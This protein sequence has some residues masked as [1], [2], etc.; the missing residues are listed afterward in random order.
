MKYL[1]LSALLIISTTVSAHAQQAK[2]V[3]GKWKIVKVVTPEITLD[4]ENI[5]A[6]RKALAKQI[7]AE[8]GETP[9]SAVLNMA[10]ESVIKGLNNSFFDFGTDGTLKIYSPVEGKEETETYTVDYT[11]N[12]LTAVSKEKNET[13]VMKIAF[14]GDRLVMNI[15]EKEGKSTIVVKRVKG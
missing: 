2:S 13:T 14:V 15:T 8:S 12:T 11:T 10:V 4:T 3:V 7:A 9:D 1:L 5:P 6:T